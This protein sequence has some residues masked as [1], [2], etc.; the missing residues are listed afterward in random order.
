MRLRS[1]VLAALAT[2]ACAV[3]P[4]SAAEAATKKKCAIPRGSDVVAKNSQVYVYTRDG[5]GDVTSRLYGCYRKTART[6]RLAESSG[7]DL[8][9]LTV[10]FDQVRV[11]GRFVAW[12]EKAT[13]ISCKADCPPG[14]EPDTYAI[15]RADL[16]TRRSL[17]WPDAHA[18]NDSLVLSKAGNTAWIQAGDVNGVFAVRVGDKTGSNAID[19]GNI[20]PTSLALT[21]TTLTWVNAGEAKN[22]TLR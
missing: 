7:D 13:D 10:E 4:A 22:A 12:Q 20:D 6:A 19:S 2:L 14:Y 18:E 16:K 1:I 9:L 8:G 15:S 21:G 11:N 3:I 5:S 17:S